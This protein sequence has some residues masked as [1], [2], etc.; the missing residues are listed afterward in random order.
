MAKWNPFGVEV[1]VTA[2]SAVVTRKSATQYTVKINAAWECT[3]SGNK[4]DYGMT[5]SSGGESVTLNSEGTKANSG[6]GSFTGTYSISGNEAASQIVSVTFTNFNTW[7]NDSATRVVSFIVDVPAWTSYAVTYN[8][9]GGSGVPGKQT[10]WKDQNLTLSNTKPTRA[11]YTFQKWNTKADG[12]GTNYT[13]GA[14]YTANADV[15]LYAVWKANTYTV[16]YNAN[17]GS[18]APGNQTKTHGTTL[19][20]S[21]TIPTRTDYAF[22][23]WGVSPTATT[24][25]YA[26]GA[27]YTNN[28]A[29]TLYAIWELTY[30]KPRIN[31]LKVDRCNSSDE[32]QDDG[33]DIRVEFDYELDKNESPTMFLSWKLSTASEWLKTT[34]LSDINKD[35]H[36]KTG[37][38]GGSFAGTFDPEKSYD[39]QLI[40]S[41]SGGST[42]ATGRISS[43]N[44]A[45]D[46]CPPDPMGV[47]DEAMFGV[48]VGKTAEL[49]GVFDMGLKA[50]FSNGYIAEVL[51][52]I[53]GA[54]VDL[55][56]IMQPG[57]YVG[58]NQAASSYS[59]TPPGLSGTFTLEV[60]SAGNAAQLMQ[61]ITS[62]SKEYPLEYV[63]H[64]YQ[65]TWGGWIRKFG[66]S[67]FDGL[68]YGPITLSEDLQKFK[69]IEIYFRDNNSNVDCGGYVKIRSPHNK[70]FE[71]SLIES[72]DG[73]NN[74][75][76]RT[77]RMIAYNKYIGCVDGINF[78]NSMTNLDGTAQTITNRDYTGKDNSQ[79]VQF[80]AGNVKHNGAHVIRITKVIGYEYEM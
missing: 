27:N 10:K 3:S 58:V 71:L 13:A 36:V 69:F 1:E 61:R 59:N 49:R 43:L 39:W 70:V 60:M 62:C 37:S 11:G 78:N 35:F 5:A 26:A 64:Y 80:Q 9:N 17:G 2:V 33:S 47:D 52:A 7:H 38:A 12:S 31:N 34:T 79:Y 68:S 21:S 18:G 29:I 67:L 53:N 46:I 51:T 73:Q 76:I 63:R 41:D 6:S 14:S 56:D 45:I 75:F 54:G 77:S 40:V 66:V 30:T 32:W 24:V 55:N 16:T 42:T 22:K 48:A 4:T 8:A 65:G 44:L 72:S 23:G 57:W 28:A 20:L 25:S 74:V 19:K 50:K 15:T